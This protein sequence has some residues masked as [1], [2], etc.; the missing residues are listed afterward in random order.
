MYSIVQ[1]AVITIESV[2]AGIK[3]M[4]FAVYSLTVRSTN[5]VAIS[6]QF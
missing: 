3:P 2:D 5:K 1:W 6:H 4:T